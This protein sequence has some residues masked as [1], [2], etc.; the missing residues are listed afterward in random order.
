MMMTIMKIMIKQHVVA[1]VSSYLFY[2][3]HSL[4]KESPSCHFKNQVIAVWCT[5]IEGK[6][7]K[8]SWHQDRFPV[9]RERPSVKEMDEQVVLA[10]GFS[11]LFPL[12]NF[13]L[14]G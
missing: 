3:H 4:D 1:R 2:F 7:R 12:S 13:L 9:K 11:R 14:A 8:R 5:Y 6:G 10:D